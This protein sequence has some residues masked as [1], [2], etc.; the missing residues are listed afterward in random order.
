[1]EKSI[2]KSSR[3]ARVRLSKKARKE[4]RYKVSGG[5]SKYAE[6]HRQQVHGKFRKTSPFVP[7]DSPEAA[8]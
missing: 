6:K 5:N 2:G 7:A 1:V 4:A 8:Q 3:R